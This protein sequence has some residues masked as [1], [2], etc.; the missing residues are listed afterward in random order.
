M[1]GLGII[2][3]FISLFLLFVGVVVLLV[4]IGVKTVR[5][6]AMIF[7]LAGGITMLL[8]VGCC[9]VSPINI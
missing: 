1:A 2:L 9:S 3:F 7:L 4:S 6:P 8:S 5:K